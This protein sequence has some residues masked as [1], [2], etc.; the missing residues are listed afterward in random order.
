MF[1]ACICKDLRFRFIIIIYQGESTV[2][3]SANAVNVKKKRKL[4]TT[5][6][7]GEQKPPY[8]ELIGCLLWISMGTRPDVS[9]AVS[10]CAK[11]SADP[12]PEH[13]KACLRILRYLKGTA[14]Y[15]LHYNKHASYYLGEQK[16]DTRKR[17]EEL[18]QPIAYTSSKY[19]GDVST[20]FLGYS[21][22][23]YANSVD[24]RRSVTGYVFIFAII[25]AVSFLKIN[26]SRNR[27]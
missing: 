23:D 27:I 10:Q 17:I 22:A 13:W 1:F 8:R 25:K 26:L 19:P 14:D 20:H 2:A 9:Y 15:G 11:F 21:D 6:T 24:D 3:G 18:Q 7:S 5:T 16:P 12:K 4:D